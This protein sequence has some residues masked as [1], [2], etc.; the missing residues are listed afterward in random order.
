MV[1]RT[2]AHVRSLPTTTTRI[3]TVGLVVW[4]CLASRCGLVIKLYV[5]ARRQELRIV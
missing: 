3:C 5:G 1:I 4:S 2:E